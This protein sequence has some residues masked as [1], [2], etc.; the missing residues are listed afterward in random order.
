MQ[1]NFP[2]HPDLAKDVSA[3]LEARGM[4]PTTFGMKAAGDPA[5]IATLERGRELR[6]G[7]LGRVRMFMLTG[8]EHRRGG[9]Q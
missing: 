2:K 5:L 1:I 3:Y 8:R 7:L 6:S 9:A 4:K